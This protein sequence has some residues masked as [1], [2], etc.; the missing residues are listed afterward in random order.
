MD[1][2]KKFSEE[3][4]P[5]KEFW[6]NT[7]QGDVPIS[8]GKL[9]HANLV[10]QQFGCK[11][12]DDY[13]NSFFHTDVLILASVFEKFRNI[14]YAMYGLDSVH[15]Y[16]ASNLSGK[17]FLKVCKA[18]SELL[19]NREHSKMAEDLIRG[20]NSCVCKTQF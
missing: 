15:F 6:K 20:G 7:L 10:F 4:L 14:W 2:F 1:T 17:A 16:T 12:L 3:K 11:T 13:Y 5:A 18:E 8:D 19:T 9:E